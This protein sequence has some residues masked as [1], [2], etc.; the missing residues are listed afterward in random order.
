MVTQLLEATSR[1]ESIHTLYTC[2]QNAS[3][4]VFMMKRFMLYLVFLLFSGGKFLHLGDQK[5]GSSNATR[6]L[7]F[8]EK[9]GHKSSHYEEIFF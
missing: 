4:F 5:V 2:F 8:L 1:R 9:I 7:F 3:S 6:T